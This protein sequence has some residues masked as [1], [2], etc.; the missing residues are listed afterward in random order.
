VGRRGL[1]EGA[2]PS[3][4]HSDRALARLAR[5][6]ARFLQ[7][8]EAGGVVLVGATVVA[9]IW[10]NSPWDASY[11][12]FW[13]TSI[14]LRIG[15]YEFS[16]DLAHWVN[17]ALMAVFFFV[18]GLEIKRELVTGELRDRRNLALPALAALGGMVVPALIFSIVNLGGD[19]A[20]GWG[21][22]MATDIAFALALVAVLGSRVPA[23]LRVFLLTLA[24]VDDIGAI[25]V[26][27]IF[28]ADDV[29]PGFLLIAAGVA[30]LV[31]IMR[32][33]RVVYWPVYVIAGLGL[34]MAVYESGVHATIAGVAMGL[35]TPARPRQSAVEAEQIVD[36]LEGRAELSADDVR[37]ISASIRD[38][39]SV[40][41]RLID[42]L[43][44]WTSYVIIPVF[45]LANAGIVLGGDTFTNP[46]AVFGGVVIGL[47]VGKFVG[48]A[49]FTWLT[50]RLGLGRLPEAVEW[51]HVAGIAALAGVGFTVSLFVT[52]LAYDSLALQE[53]AKAGILIA[54]VA[55]A[56]IGLAI[57]GFR[58]PTSPTADLD[59]GD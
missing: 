54:S 41:E 44:P 11:R 34:W 4:L 36:V 43:H 8:E 49:G 31:A 38:S 32:A 56:G 55:A 13:Q 24:I 58:K 23:P 16:E 14:D 12:S 53:Q 40:C 22:P 26:I 50:V 29:E 45:A 48:V 52:A 18:V 30:A 37:E 51:T 10:A 9:L 5:P 46:S 33:V 1:F 19:G 27:A 7:V 25:V 35:L 6:L 42:V 21:I 28:Y 57:L 3:F 47:V 59:E 39:V 17:D 20:S 2:A 15:P